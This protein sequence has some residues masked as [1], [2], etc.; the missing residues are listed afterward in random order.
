MNDTTMIPSQPVPDVA[1][2]FRL[3]GAVAIVTGAGGSIGRVASHAFAQAGARVVL[4][5]VNEA[6]VHAVADE[7]AGTGGAAEAIVMDVTDEA[8]VVAKVA[9][10]RDAYGRIDVLV[11]NAGAAI[12]TASEDTALADWNRVVAVNLTGVFLCTREVGKAML[13]QGAGSI[14]NIAS[15]MAHRGNMFY[16]NP[17]YHAT[18]GAVLTLT[19]AQAAEWGGRGIRVN[20]IAPTLVNTGFATAILTDNAMRT[21]MENRMPLGRVAEV[22]DLAGAFV[23]LASPAAA[24]VT[25]H[26]LAVDGGWLAT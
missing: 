20:A 18:K 4:S 9:K 7:I 15:I 21:V 23:Y 5:D 19:K 12:R 17:A 22:A 1:K 14:I 10:V 3:D 11:N 25:G 2:L 26:S 8:D 16:P 13:D 24:M 6:A